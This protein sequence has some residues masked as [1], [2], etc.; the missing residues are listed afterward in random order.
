M[1]SHQLKIAPLPESKYYTWFHQLKCP[2]YQKKNKEKKQKEDDRNSHPLL[3]G[4]N[5]A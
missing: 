5:R 1:Q 2:L 4:P 3:C